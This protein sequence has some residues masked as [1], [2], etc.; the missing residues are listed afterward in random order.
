MEK[1]IPFILLLACTLIHKN[2]SKHNT[3]LPPF[4]KKENERRFAFVLQC[5][6]VVADRYIV[7]SHAVD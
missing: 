7:T 4:F 1:N 6:Y 3:S 5:Q 2:T